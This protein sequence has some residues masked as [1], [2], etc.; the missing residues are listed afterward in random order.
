MTRWYGLGLLFL[1]VG[2]QGLRANGD[3]ESLDTD[4]TSS[5]TAASTTDTSTTDTEWPDVFVHQQWIGSPCSSDDT[6]AY[7]GGFCLT[8]DLGYPAGHCSQDCDLYCPD[9][10]DTPVTFCIEPTTDS[11]GHCFS[12]CDYDLYNFTDGCRPGYACVPWLR[13]STTT[14][15]LTCVPEDWTVEAPCSNPL[16]FEQDDDCYLDLVAMGDNELRELSLTLLTGSATPSQALAFLDLNFLRSQEFVEEDL[17][18]TIHD[19]NSEGHLASS[20]MRGAIVHYTAAQREDGTIRY[21]VSSSPHASTHFVIG[22]Y[23]NG[24]PVQVYSHDN[25]TWHAGSA[26]NKDR[27]G[28]DFANAGFLDPTGDGWETYSGASYEMMLP[29][30]GRNPVEISDGIPSADPNKY[31]TRDYWQPYTYYQMLSYVM[32]MRALDLVYELEPGAIERHGDVAGSRVDPGPALA[33]TA[34]NELVFNTDNLFEVTWLNDYK[35]DPHW[36]ETHPEAR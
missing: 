15:E 9:E 25:R 13:N 11:G 28:I 34:L 14:E 29:L 7:D 8:E 6:C 10:P 35:I 22:S 12:R 4:A 5:D 19:N 36:I 33:F 17:G 31:T 21:F 27:F 18:H 32:V 20:P 30:F 26:Y 16:N 1:L 3:Q 23:R 2:C 24:L